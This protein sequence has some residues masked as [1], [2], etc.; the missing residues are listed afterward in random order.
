[1]ELPSII[2]DSTLAETRPRLCDS[3]NKTSGNGITDTEMIGLGIFLSRYKVTV[4]RL[5]ARGGGSL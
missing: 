1:M 3:N 2:I 4:S 5:L